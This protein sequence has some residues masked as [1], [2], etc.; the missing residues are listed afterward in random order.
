MIVGDG[1]AFL[2]ISLNNSSV[3]AVHL[4]DGELSDIDKYTVKFDTAKAI[5]KEYP[6]KIDEFNHIYE[7]DDHSEVD[8]KIRLFLPNDKERFVMYK[9]HL[10]AVKSIIR[11]RHFLKYALTYEK[12][13]LD[14]KYRDLILDK[15]VTD[16]EI[17]KILKEVMDNLSEDE[18]YDFIRRICYQYNN[19]LEDY[20]DRKI[21]TIDMIYRSYLKHLKEGNLNP[22]VAPKK[23]EETPKQSPFAVFEHPNFFKKFGNAFDNKKPVFIF[24]GN[25]TDSTKAEYVELYNNCKKCF[26]NPIYY[27]FNANVSLPL[28]TEFT[29]I[30][31]NSIM[32]IVDGNDFNHDLAEKIMRAANKGI[33]VLILTSDEHLE[34][35]YKE[36]FSKLDTV[37]IRDYKYGTYN[38]YKM[39]ADIVAGLYIN[40]YKKRV[41][42]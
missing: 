7:I 11:N 36:N 19:Y 40:E 15:D 35:I 30:Y 28:T 27:P 23:K 21:P 37:I 32:V 22:K 8:I 6:E 33:T 3:N 9:K 18:Y 4:L 39:F 31:D 20:Q 2:C 16:S 14:K 13:L 10:V 5:L 34:Q 1:M 24:G 12:S 17:R 42:G 41:R 25:I 29:R 26:N 38:S